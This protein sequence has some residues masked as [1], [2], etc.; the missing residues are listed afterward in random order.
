MANRLHR[1]ISSDYIE[2][3][4]KLRSSR[5]PMRIV[6]YVESYD[7]I[8]FW[9]T[10]LRRFETDQRY[11]EVML[12]TRSTHLERGKKA[13]LMQTVSAMAGKHLIAC[14]DADYDYLM[15]GRTQIS[16]VMLRNPYIFHTYAYAIENLQCYASTLH[17]VCVAVTLNDRKVFDF[18][19]YLAGYSTIIYP[20]FV[21]HMLFYR[22]GR[23]KDF[24]MTDFNKVIDPG[25]VSVNSLNDCLA[26][27]EAKV[28]R[29]LLSLR[30]VHDFTHKQL[31]ETAQS[32]QQLG[33][34]PQN[35][36]LFIQGHH[37]MDVVVL[38]VM[39]HVCE[40]L[41]RQREHEIRTQAIHGTQL[42]NELSCYSARIEDI[43]SMLRKNTGFVNTPEYRAI[44]RDL[45]DYFS[46]E[47]PTLRAP[48]M[49]ESHQPQ[50]Q[51]V[52]QWQADGDRTHDLHAHQKRPF[53][54][55]RPPIEPPSG[56]YDHTA[57]Q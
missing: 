53:F 15:Q 13:V 34:V 37:L 29:K 35:T 26:R 23:Y 38:P 9:R 31:E 39:Q 10:I 25:K 4:N 24:T 49:G 16:D 21:L 28:K 44:C 47:H 48:A 41:V 11:F 54:P 36:Y 19:A 20:L 22:T 30:S 56:R 27:L 45:T 6:A 18:E 12:P 32:L 8:Y 46:A 14:I 2:A 50:A 52:P 43:T 3:A 17:E 33:L 40:I 55:H 1:H 57:E 51:D 42:R 7:D 5:S